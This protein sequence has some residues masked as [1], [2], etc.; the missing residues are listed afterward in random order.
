MKKP[1]HILVTEGRFYHHIS[2]ELLHGAEL[3][4]REQGATWELMMVPG[5]LEIPQVLSLAIDAGLFSE[6]AATP[7]HGFVAL[8]CVIRGETSHYET[9]ATGSARAL[10]GLATTHSIP[11]GNGILTVENEEQALARAAV[12]GKNKGRDAVEAC[13]EVIRIKREFAHRR[14]GESGR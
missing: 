11:V 12:N 9:V 1:I 6:T 13:L 7:F 8:G 4:L 3:T 10:M 5:A 2:D 14:A